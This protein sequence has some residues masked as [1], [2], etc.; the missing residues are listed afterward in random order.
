MTEVDVES[1]ISRLAGGKV[2]PYVV[3]MD[4][5]GKPKP[6]PPW[7]VF[8]LVSQSDG[9]V[10]CGQA[11]ELTTVQIDV[12]ANTIKEARSIR[13]EALAA[14]GSLSP[15]D[16]MKQQFRDADTG[17]FRAMLEVQIID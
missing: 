5:Q 15:G 2:Y 10:F 3:P 9:D 8:S 13:E 7:V 4:K 17:L 16:V 14:L 6:V 11:E 1:L 12:Y